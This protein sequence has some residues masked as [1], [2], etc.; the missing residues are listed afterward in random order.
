MI[1]FICRYSLWAPVSVLTSA[2]L[3]TTYI[4]QLVVVVFSRMS[5]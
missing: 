4:D 2:T 5:F 3:P 1:P